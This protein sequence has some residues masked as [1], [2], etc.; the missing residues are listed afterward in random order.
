MTLVGCVLSFQRDSD[1]PEPNRVSP[2]RDFSLC[3]PSKFQGANARSYSFGNFGLLSCLSQRLNESVRVLINDK[4]SD[5]VQK[6]LLESG[7]SSLAVGATRKELV[8]GE[9][10]HRPI[11][12]RTKLALIDIG[13]SRDRAFKLIKG[14]LRVLASDDL[15]PGDSLLL[16]RRAFSQ[17][18]AVRNDD[19]RAI[20]AR[21]T[22]PSEVFVV[23]LVSFD[24]L[25]V[26][27][28]A[29]RRKRALALYDRFHRLIPA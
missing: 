16:V 9:G 1:H 15:Q 3:S 14:L 28:V 24:E 13:P 12:I 18:K 27:P 23:L 25:S 8:L 2:E 20:C 22:D 7:W 21:M 11:V 5:I 19:K 6:G 10:V 4:R 17:W 29:H 26:G